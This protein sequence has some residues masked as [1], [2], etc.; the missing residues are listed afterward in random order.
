MFVK[1]HARKAAATGKKGLELGPFELVNFDEAQGSNELHGH[2]GCRALRKEHK[3]R[4]RQEVHRQL[5][6]N[7]H[8]GGA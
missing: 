4:S 5:V 8:N 6:D 1:M 7:E 3:A 2:P